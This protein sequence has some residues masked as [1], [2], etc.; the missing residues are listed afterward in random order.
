VNLTKRGPEI[1]RGSLERSDRCR[2]GQT[3]PWHRCVTRVL[4]VAKLWRLWSTGEAGSPRP[5]RDLGSTASQKARL[6]WLRVLIKTVVTVGLAAIV[7]WQVDWLKTL[8]ILTV[9]HVGLYAA[10][11]ALNSG[12]LVVFAL[13]TQLLSQCWGGR[14]PLR[15]MTNSHLAGR[16]ASQFLPSTIGGDVLRLVVLRRYL[17]GLAESLSVVATERLLGLVARA[18]FAVLPIVLFTNLFG[19][20]QLVT[21]AVCSVAVAS[22]VGLLLF[23][24]S[25]RLSRCF[26]PSSKTMAKILTARGHLLRSLERPWTL[27]AALGLSS[28]I[29]LAGGCSLLL[30]VSCLGGTIDLPA[31]MGISALINIV[32]MIPLSLG[33]LGLREGTAILLLAEVGIDPSMGAGVAILARLSGLL[34]GVA[35][36]PFI[37]RLIKDARGPG[38]RHQDADRPRMSP[39]LTGG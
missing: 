21:V 14:P 1:M 27:V 25:V 34:L 12:L 19:V 26:R 36:F 28:V 10:A 18:A 8:E 31:A 15:V 17:P 7:I 32:A 4:K 5:T 38:K 29:T 16:V 33:G 20:S 23:V 37:S 24:L 30:L 39:E 13:R 11:I 6:R 2:V 22:V 35:A 9:V 3:L